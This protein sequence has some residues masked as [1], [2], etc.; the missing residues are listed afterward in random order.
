M[1]TGKNPYSRL[2]KLVVGKPYH[3]GLV[4][5]SLILILFQS[6]INYWSS[7]YPAIEFCGIVELISFFSYCI[8]FIG[9]DNNLGRR[10]RIVL[11]VSFVIALASF[12][13]V[14]PLYGLFNKPF[15]IAVLTLIIS[16]LTF[17]S[18][19]FLYAIFLILFFL[20][21]SI[22]IFA[23]KGKY[24]VFGYVFMILAI[25][26]FLIPYYTIL[27]TQITVSDE[28]F[29]NFFDVRPLLHGV[30]PYSLDIA[31]LIV[32][33][34]TSGNVG[35]PTFMMTNQVVGKFVY[36]ALSL[37][38]SV[39]F[40]LLSSRASHAFSL[41]TKLQIGVFLSFL[42][43]VIARYACK[44]YY[45]RPIFTI[46]FFSVLILNELSSGV[47][48]LMLALLILAYVKL[49]SKYSWL[50]LGLCASLQELIWFP[51][52]LLVFYSINNYGWKKGLGDA[53]GALLVFLLLN[54]YFIIIGPSVF[55]HAL[56]SPLGNILPDSGGPL[57]YLVTV[58]YGGT[59]RAAAVLM[60]ATMLLGCLALLYTN[61]KKLI[62][63]LSMLPLVFIT[64]P[65]LVYTGF[66]VALLFVT[67]FLKEKKP[68]G[69]GLI[70]NWLQDNKLVLYALTLLI[71]V[72]S[73]GFVLY[74]HYQYSKAF[75]LSVTNE[76]LS[77]NNS[78]G[79]ESY[80]AVINYHN[81]ANG[82]LSLL[83]FETSKEGSGFLGAYNYSFIGNA[84]DCK[85]E[86]YP[87]E[88]NTNRIYL[89]PSNSTYPVSIKLETDINDSVTVSQLMIYNKNYIY[90][91]SPVS[92]DLIKTET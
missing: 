83:L 56:A 43:V 35:T 87:C 21:F 85:G 75:S 49:E 6:I 67:Y 82:T 58:V 63:P 47:D 28:V 77:L 16:M 64:R 41:A 71:L 48:L 8:V 88:V 12:L 20:T 90:Y 57:G 11:K 29:I 62:A 73:A 34:F 78:T 23:R 46:A 76:K 36:P 5:M 42:F 79:V 27:K 55:I 50:L 40:Y 65:I 81:L 45:R 54:S 72:S 91:S 89:N 32:S 61:N 52:L 17:L 44:D 74:S 25:L 53:L 10:S 13:A 39:P 30:N 18:P 51:V 38:V 80:T 14:F 69:R 24:R 7:L 3:S 33:N 60:I 84:V 2:K 66:F 9:S 86:V 22:G 70:G 31:N 19:V 15:V 92:V 4:V 1:E 59:F 26:V 68:T 37:F